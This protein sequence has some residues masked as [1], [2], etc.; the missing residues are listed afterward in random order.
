M[1]ADEFCIKAQNTLN[2]LVFL[3]YQ[4]FAFNPNN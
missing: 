4:N 3:F 1:Q 2:P